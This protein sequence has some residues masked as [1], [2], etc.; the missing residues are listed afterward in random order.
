LAV[1]NAMNKSPEPFPETL[2]VPLVTL[3]P[4]YGMQ[5]TLESR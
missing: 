5:M 4:R 3:R 2:P 1:E